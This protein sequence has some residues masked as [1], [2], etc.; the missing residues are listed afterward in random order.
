MPEVQGPEFALFRAERSQLQAV[1]GRLG[2]AAAPSAE[3]DEPLIATLV[4]QVVESVIHLRRS[5]NLR[6]SYTHDIAATC[7][8]LIGLGAPE[9]TRARHAAGRL[10]AAASPPLSNP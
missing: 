3:L 8:R 1:Y 10:L 2:G 7:L 9:V 4:M 5:G 6:D